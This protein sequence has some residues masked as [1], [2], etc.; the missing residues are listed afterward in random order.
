MVAVSSFSSLQIT[1]TDHGWLMKSS[2]LLR[3]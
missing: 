1:A 3:S 2:P